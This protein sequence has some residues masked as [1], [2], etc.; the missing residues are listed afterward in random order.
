M[1]HRGMSLLDIALF[2]FVKD[3]TFEQTFAEARERWTAE[4]GEGGRYEGWTAV[5]GFVS[6]FD[7]NNYTPFTTEEGEAA[8]QYTPPQELQDKAA[9]G[10]EAAQE[11]MLVLV[12]PA[13]CRQLLDNA[14]VDVDADAL[15]TTAQKLDTLETEKWEGAPTSILDAQAGIAAV[16]VLRCDLDAGERLQWARDR[17]LD[18]ART[19]RETYGGLVPWEAQALAAD[20][21][22]AVWA[23]TP[24]DAAIR[25]AIAH[26]ARA[27]S[28]DLVGR[29][30]AA[31]MRQRSDLGD[32]HLRLLHLIHR[33]ALNEHAVQRLR[34]SVDWHGSNE[35]TDEASEAAAELATLEEERAQTA[36]AFVD[37]TLPASLPPFPE[38]SV[39][40]PQ[41]RGAAY[42]RRR[43]P[44]R[45]ADEGLLV[46]LYSGIPL[47]DE[48]EDEW[49]VWSDLWG[50]SV[51]YATSYLAI[52][53]DAPTEDVD[54]VDGPWEQFVWT[55]AAYLS[56]RAETDEDARSYWAPVLALGPTASFSVSSFLRDWGAYALDHPLD[57]TVHRRWGQMIEFAAQHPRW[58][59]ADQRGWHPRADLWRLLVGL[60]LL[61]S[62]IW[63]SERVSLA[64]ALAPYLQRWA[65]DHP[66]DASDLVALAMF[67][68]FPAARASRLD[69]LV[70]LDDAVQVRGDGAWTEHLIGETS[71]FSRVET[72]VGQLLVTAWTTDR[73]KLRRHNEAKTAF[74]SL[75]GI[76]ASRRLPIALE[77]S[78]RVGQE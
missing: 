42:Q 32:D 17:L 64:Q 58:S 69:G 77:L 10:Q 72:A 25:E 70:W 6:Q 66:L 41:A 5:E 38:P 54:G 62:D 3:E 65:A 63:S 8:L 15:W 71:P 35:E 24:H 29:L 9:E 1:D 22:P 39:A 30:T 78:Q 36:R 52:S 47:P 67:L 14:E 75:L 4:L 16:L 43:R 12:V 55:H 11:D 7:R 73:A 59:R 44:H 51:A 57:D 76:L 53:E 19:I 60:Q 37:G 46:A 21:L 18:A 23:R 20:A 56:R 61:S 40:P 68:S 31:V 34:R 26:L 48:A 50:R 2:Y 74:Q 49:P 45:Q 33:R 13:Q 28:S 27:G